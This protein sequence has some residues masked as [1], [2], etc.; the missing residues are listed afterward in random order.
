MMLKTNEISLSNSKSSRIISQIKIFK[1]TSLRNSHKSHI[2]LRKQTR[3]LEAMEEPSDF[4]GYFRNKKIFEITM[5]PF[6][7][8]GWATTAT[9]LPSTRL[10]IAGTGARTRSR[11]WVYS[12][13]EKIQSWHRGAYL[14]FISLALAYRHVRIFVYRSYL[15]ACSTRWAYVAYIH[16]YDSVVHRC[17]C[18][19]ICVYINACVYIMYTYACMLGPPAAS[20]FQLERGFQSGGTAEKIVISRNKRYIIPCISALPGIYPGELRD[21]II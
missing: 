9:H 2:Y 4:L 16:M 3:F 14:R 18:G 1:I 15:R 5:P 19:D 12:R 8:I 13:A 17:E 10:Y 20:I 11:I 7:I 6:L 21:I